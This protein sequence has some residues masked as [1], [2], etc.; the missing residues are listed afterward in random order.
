MRRRGFTLVEILVALVL[1]GLLLG[2]GLM[3]SHHAPTRAGTRGA[4]ETV[5]EELRS[6][7]KKAAANGQ[8]CALALPTANGTRPHS[9]SLYHLE[10]WIHPRLTRVVQLGGDFPRTYLL[11]G[12]WGNSN[13]PLTPPV[14][15]SNF[16]LNTWQ[17][18]YP[19]DAT[20]L[21]L[22][23]GAVISNQPLVDGAYRILL[24]GGLSYTGGQPPF[25]INGA[26]DSITVALAPTGETWLEPG[27][28]LP[29]AGPPTNPPAPAP[30][31]TSG[32]NHDPDRLD[33]TVQPIPNPDSLP[34]GASATVKLK[35]HLTLTAEA[36]DPDGDPL[37]LEWTTT[38]VSPAGPGGA[39]SATSQ[40]EMQWDPQSST[41]KSVWEWRPP[42][43][44]EGGDRYR[45]TATV[46]DGRNGT[47][48]QG[49]GATGLVEI[50]IGG[51]IVFVSNRDG[52]VYDVFTMN[53]DGTDT[54]RLTDDP[55]FDFE[56]RWS[57]DGSK[58]VFTSDRYGQSEVLLMER[59]G[60]Q[61]R[62]ITNGPALGLTEILFTNF[63]PDGAG[64]VFVGDRGGTV[65]VYLTTLQG[66]D[67]RN[68]G[69]PG[70]W[71]LTNENWPGSFSGAL[72]PCAR[73]V[74]CHPD[75]QRLVV[76][77]GT[78][79]DEDLYEVL[80]GGV[81]T[82]IVT[83][84]A[85]L[86][87]DQ[88]E[89][90]L[91]LDGSRLTWHVAGQ[92]YAYNAPAGAPGSL[93][94]ATPM[95][96]VESPIFSPDGSRLTYQSLVGPGERAIFVSDVNGGNVQRLTQVPGDCDSSQWSVR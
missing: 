11:T 66:T 86:P 38:E 78:S 22:P 76:T 61:V 31:L 87:L 58:I 40:V 27:P 47:R 68:P 5:A 63:T 81:P 94:A 92:W 16:P 84:L 50:L 45:L 80:Y 67:P 62:R 85:S 3:T 36:T 90:A 33:V 79:P 74:I 25:T 2:I 26:S 10:G 91:N 49:L 89:P 77:G 60:S 57:P 21:F 70:A 9:Q 43:Q 44:A 28:A 73:G 39:Y 1:M 41:W 54:T 12:S 30:P 8:P 13:P 34:P 64:I 42:P 23:S 6:A 55:Y 4:A 37:V 46:R 56:P 82:P 95:A 7:R 59:D 15:G 83:R 17:A 29:P 19:D 53:A 32:A 52:G 75:G 20:F 18:P 72:G 24:A 88:A 69:L 51:K 65:D 48:S 71:R 96:S 35:G 93:G 14:N